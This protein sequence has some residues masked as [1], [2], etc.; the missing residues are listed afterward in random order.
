MAASCPRIPY[1]EA[2]IRRILLK[3]S[4][5]LAL[6]CI[7]DAVPHKSDVHPQD[8]RRLKSAAAL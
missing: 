8:G 7:P 4:A 3:L 6:P 5:D 1:G 2:D